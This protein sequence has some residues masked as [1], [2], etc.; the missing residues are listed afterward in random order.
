MDKIAKPCPFSGPPY[1]GCWFWSH[2]GGGV[3]LIGEEPISLHNSDVSITYLLLAEFFRFIRAG[4]GRVITNKKDRKR[5]RRAVEMR[6]SE[7]IQYTFIQYFFLQQLLVEISRRIW[8]IWTSPQR[9]G[10]QASCVRTAGVE[11]STNASSL[12]IAITFDLG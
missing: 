2:P 5:G 12:A 8:D 9:I 3:S 11:A 10:T 7:R 4:L 6:G 1:S